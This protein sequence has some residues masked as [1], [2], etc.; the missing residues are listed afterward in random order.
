M[1][2]SI[3]AAVLWWLL[4]AFAAYLLLWSCSAAW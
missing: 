4:V 2:S 3:A 1:M